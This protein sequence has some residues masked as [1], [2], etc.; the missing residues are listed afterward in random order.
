MASGGIGVDPYTVGL[1][2]NAV[3]PEWDVPN[4]MARPDALYFDVYLLLIAA[5]LGGLLVLGWHMRRVYY[6][7]HEPRA[8]QSSCGEAMVAVMRRVYALHEPAAAQASCGE[9][10]VAA[11]VASPPSYTPVTTKPPARTP[12]QSFVQSSVQN[13]QT[14]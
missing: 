2:P 4:A 7:L 12:V 3:I 11:A 5:A 9:A 8:A 14:V 10:M 6:G 1:D 13:E